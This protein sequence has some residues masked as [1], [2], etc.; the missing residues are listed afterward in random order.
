[1]Q[2]SR[3]RTCVRVLFMRSTFSPSRSLLAIGASGSRSASLLA[4]I[5]P[6]LLSG[7]LIT[8]PPR[9]RRHCKPGLQPWSGKDGLKL[10]CRQSNLCFGGA[11]GPFP[12]KYSFSCLDHPGSNVLE[13]RG[14]VQYLK[15]PMHTNSMCRVDITQVN[16]LLTGDSGIIYLTFFALY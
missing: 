12:C 15:P 13:F 1:M 5:A 8:R 10:I 11:Q 14:N 16:D 9:S 6:Q 7:R 4:S 3:A 2:A